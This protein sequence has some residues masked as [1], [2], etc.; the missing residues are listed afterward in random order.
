MLQKLIT[1]RLFQSSIEK[2]FYFEKLD[3]GV[4]IFKM[5]RAKQRN[6]IS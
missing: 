1:K 4:V 6:A 5:N 2:H 3:K